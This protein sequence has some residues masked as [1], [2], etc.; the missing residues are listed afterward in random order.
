MTYMFLKSCRVQKNLIIKKATYVFVVT[1]IIFSQSGQ[2]L[3]SSRVINTCSFPGWTHR[4]KLTVDSSKVQA[5]LNNYPLYIDLSTFPKK[6]F[7]HVNSDGGDIRVSAADGITQLPRE[8]VTIDT[9][10]QTGEV[11]FLAPTLSSDTDTNFYVYFGNSSASDYDINDEFGRNAV[12]KDYLAVY[13]FEENSTD[14][15]G[16]G[17]NGTDTDASYG[18]EYGKLSGQGV[19]LSGINGSRISTNLIPLSRTPLTVSAWAYYNSG[20]PITSAKNIWTTWNY[21]V[22]YVDHNSYFGPITS[23]D[24]RM[25]D[26]QGITYS[27]PL[28]TWK[29]TTWVST[30]GEEKYA[31]F[32]GDFAGAGNN[33]D[34]NDQPDHYKFNIGSQGDGTENWLGHIDEVRVRQEQMPAEWI[35]VEYSNQSSPETFY[36]QSYEKCTYKQHSKN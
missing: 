3:S 26:A 6:F 16:G 17:N 36:S 8:I 32:D 21:P 23:N 9:S 20:N 30:G 35:A 5:N 25:G 28:Q 2:A 10:N 14:S 31:Y 29:Y 18:S 1:L 27:F 34:G 11:H 33:S 15:T 7:T 4:I 24:V 19:T 22:I 13:H 12:W